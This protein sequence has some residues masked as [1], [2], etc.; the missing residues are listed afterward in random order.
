MEDGL[1]AHPVEDAALE[2]F[3]VLILVVVEDGL[4]GV[5]ACEKITKW[6]CLNPCCCGRWSQRFKRRYFLCFE[7]KVLILVVVEDGLRETVPVYTPRA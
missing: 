5:E 6:A 3:R 1:R 4:R 7:R 2:D